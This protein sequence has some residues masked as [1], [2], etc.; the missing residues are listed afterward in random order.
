M[1]AFTVAQKEDESW[2][3]KFN[4]NAKFRAE[5][6]FNAAGVQAEE[7]PAESAATPWWVWLISGLGGAAL[8]GVVI[9]IIVVAKKKG[10]TVVV[11]GDDPE[12][13]RRLNRHDEMLEELL[14][15]DDGGFSAHVDVDDDGN[16]I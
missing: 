9:I 3:I 12:T 8:I 6:V 11:N 4:Y 10:G 7:Q 5:V 16:I 2:I 13:R 1:E 14:N 15:R